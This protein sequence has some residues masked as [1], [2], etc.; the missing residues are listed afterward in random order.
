M[1]E[2]KNNNEIKK[3]H[4]WRLCPAGEHWVR[5]HNLHI[6]PSEKHPEGYDTIR[7]AHCA[8]NPSG[9]D[10]LYIGEI[11]EISDKNFSDVE[12][13][14]CSLKLKF[15][16][17]GKKFDSLIAGWT[18]YWN[19]VLSPKHLL[20]PNLVKALIASESSF[21][22]DVLANKKNQNSAR[23]LMQLTN[24]SRKIL[25]DEKGELKNH[26]ISV[27]REEL[28]NPS[29]NICAGIRWLFNKQRL[30]SSRFGR[31]ATW[32]ESVFEYKGGRTTT[33]E[34]INKLMNRFKEL[35]EA[36]TKCKE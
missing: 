23:G 34:E 24:S 35:F 19:D 33:T 5:T 12:P 14:P 15:G 22:P 9:K 27:S 6:S 29:I 2:T 31:E 20:D 4:P 7:H 26:F 13:K 32:E 28:N 30:T 36:Y 1:E 8:R 25:G 18:K 10:Q 3:I 21:D 17:N 11:I 16:E